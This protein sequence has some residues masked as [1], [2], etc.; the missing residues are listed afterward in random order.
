MNTM[1]PRPKRMF[2]RAFR[3]YARPF[4]H[5]NFVFVAVGMLGRMAA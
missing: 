4:Q 1:T 5:K 2:F 3:H